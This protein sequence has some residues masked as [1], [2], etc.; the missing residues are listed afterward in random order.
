MGLSTPTAY[1]PGGL[2]SLL[3]GPVEQRLR[4]SLTRLAMAERELNA[5]RVVDLGP[6]ARAIAVLAAD[7]QALPEEDGRRLAPMLEALSDG[8]RSIAEGLTVRAQACGD[9]PESGPN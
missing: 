7:I 1:Q 3:E 9:G 8:L 4:A 6:F 2:G 5:G